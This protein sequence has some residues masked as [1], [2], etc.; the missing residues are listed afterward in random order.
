MARQASAAARAKAATEAAGE[1]GEGACDSRLAPLDPAVLI[2]LFYRKHAWRGIDWADSG[3][4]DSSSESSAS[5]PQGARRHPSRNQ[6][7]DSKES[8]S[9]ADI[10]KEGRFRGTKRVTWYA[11]D[12]TA[13]DTGEVDLLQERGT[14]PMWPLKL[15]L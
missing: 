10:A 13:I 12:V 11:S 8:T 6:A 1:G 15:Q 4:G 9:A 2:E 7:Q 5:K 3:S 14:L